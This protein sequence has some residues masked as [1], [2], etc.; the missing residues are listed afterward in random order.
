MKP[1]IYVYKITFEEVPYYYYGVHKE[2]RYNEEYWGSPKTNKWCWELYTTKK[3]ILEIFDYTDDG[4]MEAQKVENRIIKPVFNSD[5]WCLNESCG[6]IISL[7]VIRETRKNNLPP[8]L[9]KKHS[10]ETKEKMRLSQLGKKH[11]NETKERISMGKKGSIPWN[12]GKPMSE[13]AKK[14]LSKSIDGYKWWTNGQIT[15]RC[16]ECPGIEWKRGRI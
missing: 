8:N 10:Q 11:S 2:K 4:W 13:D 9:G 15:K 14:R 6:S 16:V 12:K 1:R 3:Q 7:K 5:K